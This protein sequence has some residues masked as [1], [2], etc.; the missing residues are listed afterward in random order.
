MARIEFQAISATLLFILARPP[1]AT[2]QVPENPTVAQSVGVNIHFRNPQTGE[3]NMLAKTGVGWVRVDYLW[4]YVE[5]KPGEYD[6]STYD[7]LMEEFDVFHIRPIFIL[8]YTNPLYDEDLSPHSDAGR[9]AFAAW[10]AASAAHFRERG[11]LWEIYNEPNRSFWKP[12]VNVQ[13]Y[14]LL[15]QVTTHAILKAAPG[16]AVIG[17]AVWGDDHDFLEACFQAHLLDSWAAVSIHPY[18]GE[19]NPETVTQTYGSLR[20]LMERYKPANREVPIISSEWGYSAGSEKGEL[21]EALQ[22]KL[23][24]RQWL[25]NLSERIPVSIWY[26]WRDKDSGAR[27]GLV[28]FPY[29]AGANPVYQPKIAYR[30]AATLT[31]LLRGFRMSRRVSLASNDDYMLEFRRGREARFAVWSERPGPHA[32]AVLLPGGKYSVTDFKGDTLPPIST[33]RGGRTTLT[34]TDGPIYLAP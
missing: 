1:R 33:T 3:L 16:E 22:G 13:D 28:S 29:H 18:R 25:V 7:R 23:L 5:K 17:P 8:D 31:A 11:I 21:D 32:V 14:V 2:G 30:A 19:E 34:V 27:Y 24:A 15:A 9:N 12:E 26:C 4:T 10:A 6:F 20:R